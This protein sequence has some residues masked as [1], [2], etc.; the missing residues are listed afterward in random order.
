MTFTTRVKGGGGGGG[1]SPTGPAGGDLLGNYPNPE[2]AD[3]SHEHTLATIQ[4]PHYKI[5][6]D[7]SNAP[8]I[9][10]RPLLVGESLREVVVRIDNAFNVGVIL[11]VGFP[12]D[13]N[14]ILKPA[15]IAPTVPGKYKANSYRL[16]SV[17]ESLTLYFGGVIPT[18]G[19]GIVFVNLYDKDNP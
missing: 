17:A 12:A 8:E 18:Q 19:S 14:E 6:F 10:L 1:G 15:A 7:F 11:S 16:S 4:F 3:D 13:H 5:P 2:V 9:L